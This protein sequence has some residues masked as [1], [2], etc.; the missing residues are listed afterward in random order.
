M[1]GPA[2][3]AARYAEAIRLADRLTAHFTLRA[4]CTVAPAAASFTPDSLIAAGALPVYRRL[5]HASLDQAERA[6]VMRRGDDGA[7][8]AAVRPDLR[9]ALADLMQAVP[10]SSTEAVL[11]FPA[12][13]RLRARSPRPNECRRLSA[14]PHRRP[15][16][17]LC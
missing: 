15:L 14:H 12:P 10:E 7:R 6:G 2:W 17:K 8:T 3:D 11:H 4:A 1:T 5:L 16:S 9:V 13:G